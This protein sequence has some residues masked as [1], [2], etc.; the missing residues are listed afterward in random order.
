MNLS[1]FQTK[2]F[3]YLS[4]GA[5][6]ITVPT[7]EEDRC[8]LEILQLAKMAGEQRWKVFRWTAAKGTVGVF[9]ENPVA[10]KGTIQ[11]LEAACNWTP[12]SGTLYILCD[13]HTWPVQEHPILNRAMRDLIEG[14]G[15]GEYTVLFVGPTIK[16]A[17]TWEK[18]AVV[19]PFEL[20]DQAALVK[21]VQLMRTTFAPQI[22]HPFPP[23]DENGVARALAGLTQAEASNVLALSCVVKG[24]FDVDL[25][26]G[27]KVRAV[28]RGGLLEVL[29]TVDFNTVGGLD[30]L[31]PWIK[32][33]V[34]A[35]TPAA[36]KFNLPTPKGAMLVG[37]PGSGKSL[38]ARA[39]GHV[40]GMPVLKMDVGS[41]FGSMLGESENK[42]RG[43]IALAEK[44]APCILLLDEIDKGF[45]GTG[46]NSFS[47]DSGTTKRVFGTFLSWLQDKTS[48]VFVVATANSVEGLPPEI[49]RKGRFD[50]LW[51]V[52]LPNADER[53]AIVRIHLEK[54]GRKPDDFD[55]DAV[56]DATDGFV[57]SEIESVVGDGLY[58]AFDA[59]RE[60]TTEDLI[61]AAK[62]TTPL[63]K[64]MAESIAATRSWARDRAR[65]A[66]VAPHDRPAGVLKKSRRFVVQ[67]LGTN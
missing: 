13:T 2:L 25:I 18:R 9:P 59:E 43:A 38:C 6:C 17:D 47:G 7:P 52:D 44:M 56:V 15:E 19:L 30:G 36:Q 53:E 33:R 50:E 39:M 11:Q 58:D 26:Y 23:Y 42:M 35:F 31:K 24:G 34:R 4:S 55:L 46:A 61:T 63:S 60:L 27:E 64:T 1:H 21:T 54:R 29:D 67:K 41:L 51:F 22:S 65:A 20:P 32:K 57:G 62:G 40:L 5:P 16:Y 45:A 49:L 8:L 10:V 28:R 48:Q 37:V 12:P 3:E 66:S 14:A